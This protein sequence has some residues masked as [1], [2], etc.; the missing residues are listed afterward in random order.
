M[1]SVQRVDCSGVKL[2]DYIRGGRL[3]TYWNQ[4]EVAYDSLKFK[5]KPNIGVPYIVT[6]IFIILQILVVLP[7]DPSRGLRAARCGHHLH[8]AASRYPSPRPA[9][10]R[11]V[12]ASAAA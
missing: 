11:C 9:A 12:K 5:R 3:F 6:V 2:A 1:V 10:S 4:F 7:L 8:A